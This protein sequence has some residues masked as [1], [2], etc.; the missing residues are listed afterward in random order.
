MSQTGQDILEAVRSMRKLMEDVGLLLQ[1]AAS[2]LEQSG[3]EAFG[4][5]AATADTS[6]SINNPRKWMPRYAFRFA[7]HPQRPGVL[8]FVSVILDHAS[9]LDLVREPLAGAGWMTYAKETVTPDDMWYWHARI[10]LWLPGRKDDGS[11]I[12]ADAEDLPKSWNVSFKEVS[13]LAVPLVEIVNAE[14]I[15]RRITGPLEQAPGRPAATEPS[16]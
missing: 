1:T 2:E 11:L 12:R 7:T 3:W 5:N 8:A 9:E 14:A 4:T 13:T 16:E 6:S 10:H 15:R